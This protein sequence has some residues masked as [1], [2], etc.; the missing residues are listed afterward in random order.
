MKDLFY[1]VFYK[2]S[3]FYEN[4]GEKNGYIG[5]GIVATGSLCFIF[6]SITV[7]VLHYWFNKKINTNIVWIMVIIASI[8]SLFLRK[9]NMKN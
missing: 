2:A 8:L 4:W 1:Y 6:L 3:K 5:G 9:K 7:F